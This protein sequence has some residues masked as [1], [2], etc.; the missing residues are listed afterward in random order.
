MVHDPLGVLDALM[1]AVSG[2]FIVFLMLAVLWGIIVIIS[3]AVT[4]LAGKEQ[5]SAAAPAAP[6]PAPAPMPVPAA[7]AA[8]VLEGIDETQAACVMAIVSHETGIPLDELVFKSI[9]AV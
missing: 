4:A 8:V 1:I 9:K 3:R 5:Q 7:P 6:A 2:F